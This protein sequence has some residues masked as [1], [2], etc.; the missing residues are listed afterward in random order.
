MNFPNNEKLFDVINYESDEIIDNFI[1]NLSREQAFYCL[2]EA[3]KCAVKRGTY[4]IVENE[5]IS[6]S[7]RVISMTPQKNSTE[8]FENTEKDSNLS[9]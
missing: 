1:S 9:S 7:L 8:N 3:A 4:S 6:K 2:I 5:L